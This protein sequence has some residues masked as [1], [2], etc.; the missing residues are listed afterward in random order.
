M[1]FVDDEGHWRER[2]VRE[3][4]DGGEG[5]DTSFGGVVWEASSF[6][7]VAEGVGTCLPE[8]DEHVASVTLQC[9]RWS[10]RCSEELGCWVEDVGSRLS[11]DVYKS[12]DHLVEVG[13]EL[14]REGVVCGASVDVVVGESGV[15]RIGEVRRGHVVA[16]P[17]VELVDGGGDE[18]EL[19]DEEAVVG[20][21]RVGNLVD[22]RDGLWWYCR[23][24]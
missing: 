20:V 17:W 9:V 18:R 19:V 21:G 16:A 3:G 6:V 22:L 15:R 2:G 24:W 23:E 14:A 10:V 7:F 12:F 11:R 5:L 8:V 4:D 13:V 1:R